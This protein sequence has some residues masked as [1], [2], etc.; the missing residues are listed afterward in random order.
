MPIRV[1]SCMNVQ[2]DTTAKRINM[3]QVEHQ[4]VYF[5][6]IKAQRSKVLYVLEDLKCCNIT[7]YK[8]NISF[9]K[10]VGSNDYSFIIE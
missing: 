9:E 4:H 10:S 5:P 2:Y 8:A 6:S 1:R 3:T 7:A